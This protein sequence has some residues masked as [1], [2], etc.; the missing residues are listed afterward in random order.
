MQHCKLAECPAK[1]LLKDLTLIN[2]EEAFTTVITFK[3]PT[4]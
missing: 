1:P 2:G 4:S 3:R